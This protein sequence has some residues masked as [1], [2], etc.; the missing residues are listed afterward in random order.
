MIRLFIFFIC[1]SSFLFSQEFDKYWTLTTTFGVDNYRIKS[2]GLEGMLVNSFPISIQKQ[3]SPTGS[4]GLYLSPSIYHTSMF[5]DSDFKGGMLSSGVM[6]NF[7]LYESGL[8]GMHSRIYSGATYHSMKK[9]TVDKENYK[10]FG[11][12]YQVG[13]TIGTSYM[14]S[15]EYGEKKPFAF[16]FETGIQYIKHNIQENTLEFDGVLQN[17]P[18]NDLMI[19]DPFAFNFNLCMGIFIYINRDLDSN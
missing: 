16:F 3:F 11:F 9:Y 19:E 12:G 14:L 17:T 5:S 2:E 13:A 8:F 18:T 7:K 10:Q 15:D 1:L 4:F 6:A